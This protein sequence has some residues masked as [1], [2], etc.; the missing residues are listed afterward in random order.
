MRR[1]GRQAFG[2]A[3]KNAAGF[4][5]IEVMIAV[6]VLGFGLLGF[7]LLQTMSVR[8]V[9]SANYRTQATNLSY[10]LLDQIRV[11]RVLVSAYLGDYTASVDAGDCEPVT[12]PGVSADDFAAAWQCRMGKALGEGATAVVAQNGQTVQ[13]SISWG[14][15]RWVA[16]AA[17]TTFVASTRL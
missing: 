17:D 14:D 8:F 16:D 15:E 6:V 1:L 12:G 10:E 2:G 5:L 11:N 7:A 3:A 4:T 13:V 9:Q